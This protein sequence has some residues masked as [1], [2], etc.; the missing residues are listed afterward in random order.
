MGACICDSSVLQQWTF[1]GSVEGL[2]HSFG[3]ALP[4]LEHTE[5]VSGR[6]GSHMF[7]GFPNQ[8]RQISGRLLS[9]AEPI[10]TSS[11]APLNSRLA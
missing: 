3:R 7:Q 2:H 6:P 1:D 5:R 4:D 10:P 8:V 11:S 9:Y